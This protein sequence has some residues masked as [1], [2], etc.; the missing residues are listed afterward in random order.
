MARYVVLRDRRLGGGVPSR[1][2]L[3]IVNTDAGQALG[4]AF[5]QIK[6]V[7]KVNTLFILCH[8]YAGSNERAQVSMDAGGMGLQLGREGVFISNVCLWSALKN[9]VASIVIYSCAAAD[10]QPGNEGTSADGRYLMGAL[11]LHTN[12]FVYAADKIQWYGTYK[13]LSNG[14]FDWGAW[15]GQLW[16]FPPDGS[17]PTIVPSAPIEFGDVMNGTAP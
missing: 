10:T 4:N 1:R 6:A 11:A 13:N 17:P 9:R 8:G 3:V 5:M 14:R 15:E 2:G 12:A 16:Q 7:G